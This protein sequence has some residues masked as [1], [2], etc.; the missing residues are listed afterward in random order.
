MRSS[1]SNFTSVLQLVHAMGVRP[2]THDALFKLFLEVNN[3][4]GEIQVLGDAFGVINVV[5][6]A[7]PVLR[8]AV[9][10]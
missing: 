9:P 6:R 2:L 1:G 10:L 7:T 4:V 3:V 5:Q 8:R